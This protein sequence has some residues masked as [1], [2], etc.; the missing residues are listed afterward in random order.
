V[1]E[2]VGHQPHTGGPTSIPGQFMWGLW[3]TECHMDRFFGEYFG[4]PCHHYTSDP[5][6]SCHLRYVMSAIYSIVKITYVF[7]M[8][9]QCALCE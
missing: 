7:I 4:F 9:V 6:P 2:V 8:K 3:W 5:D 1:A